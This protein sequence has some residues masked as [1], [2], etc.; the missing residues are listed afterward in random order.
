MLEYQV[1]QRKKLFYQLLDDSDQ[2]N[3][4]MCKIIGNDLDSTYF[5]TTLGSIFSILISLI[6]IVKGNHSYPIFLAIGLVGGVLAWI[7]GEKVA[8]QQ[9]RMKDLKKLHQYIDSLL[10]KTSKGWDQD[11][12]DFRNRK[13]SAEEILYYMKEK[14][15]GNGP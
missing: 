4:E 3:K 5:T 6:L 12:E 7:M 1:A 9:N 2:V 13:I 10:D 14:G 11:V 8:K 15:R